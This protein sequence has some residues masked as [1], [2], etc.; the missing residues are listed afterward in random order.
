MEDW[1]DEVNP[2]PIPPKEPR[3]P[4]EQRDAKGEVKHTAKIRSRYHSAAVPETA[5]NGHRAKTVAL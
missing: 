4:K 2:H 3:E 1:A 5:E